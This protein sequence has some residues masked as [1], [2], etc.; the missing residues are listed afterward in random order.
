M[1]YVILG[2][3][4]ETTWHDDE[5]FP[6]VGEFAECPNPDSGHGTQEIVEAWDD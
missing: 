3:G 4:C 1:K 6:G 5:L 2:C